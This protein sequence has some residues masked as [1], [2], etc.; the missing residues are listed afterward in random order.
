MNTIER[1]IHK[2]DASDQAYGRLASQIAIILRGKNKAE[3]LPSV[4][5][6]KRYYQHL[7]LKNLDYIYNS[8]LFVIE[9]D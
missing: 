4:N 6:K 7:I 5:V 2:I 9:K 3:F 1:K 8:P